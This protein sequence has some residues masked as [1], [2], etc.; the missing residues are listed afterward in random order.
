VISPFAKKNY[1]SHTV[2]DHTAILT[3]IEKRFGLSALTERDKSQSD[4]STDFFD[5]VNVPWATPPTP[6]TQVTNGTCSTAPP[7]PKSKP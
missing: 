6:P 4:M 1:V 3:L 2:Y 7:T 5:F